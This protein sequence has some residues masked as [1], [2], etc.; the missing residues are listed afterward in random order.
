MAKEKD[1]LLDH[2]YD[3]IKELDNDLPPWWVYLF[4]FTI[5]FSVVYFIYYH[6]T[7]MGD[8]PIAELHKE[9]DPNWEKSSSDGPFSAYSSPFTVSEGDMTPYLQEQFSYYIG[10]NVTSEALMMTA[11]QRANTEQLE[12]LKQAFPNL[13]EKLITSEGP[14]TAKA[15]GESTA[16][17][18]SPPMED[19][20]PLIDAGSL[21]EGKDIFIRN[22]VSCHGANGEGG[23]GPNMTDDYW[24]HGAKMSE[25]VYI[26]INGVPAKGMIPWRGT[27]SDEQIIKVSSFLQTLRGTNPENAKAPQG[28][29][30]ELAEGEGE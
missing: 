15:I 25:M 2:D 13:W 18:T 8:L 16:A 23:I 7:D 19:I 6:V 22:C 30:V 14:I 29:L 12:K 5:V 27:L 20:K 1:I 28:E 9:Y 26:I 11:M 3:G 4:Y 21:T 24:I 10:Q 17:G